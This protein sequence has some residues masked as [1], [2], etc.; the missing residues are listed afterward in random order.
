[1]EAEPSAEMSVNLY[2]TTQGYNP[3][4]NVWSKVSCT[5]NTITNVFTDRLLNIK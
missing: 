3:Q 5:I 2:H 1:M 4:H